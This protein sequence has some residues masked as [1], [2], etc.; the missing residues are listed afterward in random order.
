MPVAVYVV[1][2]GKVLGEDALRDYLKARI[3]GFKV[4]EKMWLSDTPLPRLGTEKVDRRAVKARYA[5]MWDGAT[6]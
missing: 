1:S 3:A 5:A 4:P 6:G 2:E